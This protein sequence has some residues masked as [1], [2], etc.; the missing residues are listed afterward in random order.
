MLVVLGK[1]HGRFV[2][3][4]GFV[5]CCCVGLSFACSPVDFEMDSNA[6]MRMADEELQMKN[7]HMQDIMQIIKLVKI[8]ESVCVDDEICLWIVFCFLHPFSHSFLT[9]YSFPSLTHQEFWE[10]QSSVMPIFKHFSKELKLASG[11][12]LS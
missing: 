12:T 1:S 6:K 11:K 5:M 3:V 9:F 10:G 2:F 7:K 8:S 4:F